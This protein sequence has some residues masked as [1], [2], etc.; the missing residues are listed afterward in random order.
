ME[1]DTYQRNKGEM[2][3]SLVALQPLPIH[4]TIWIEISINFIMELTNERNKSNIVVVVDY[5]SKFAHFYALQ[6]PFKASIVSQVFINNVL[7]YM[8]C[9]IQLC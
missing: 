8:A 6:H 3:K 9:L 2:V 1:C 4:A 5:L 7:K